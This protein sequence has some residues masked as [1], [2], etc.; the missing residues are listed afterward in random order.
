M[1]ITD[2]ECVRFCELMDSLPLPDHIA[3]Q[4][5]IKREGNFKRVL[6]MVGALN[7]LNRR[8]VR[9]RDRN[10]FAPTKMLMLVVQWR[11]NQ[12]HLVVTLMPQ[13]RQPPL[14]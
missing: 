6:D 13:L 4:R 3:L 9:E 10:V 8:R 14:T 5:D 2:P 12:A 1:E 7:P 11:W